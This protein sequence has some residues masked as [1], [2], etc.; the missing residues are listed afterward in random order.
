LYSLNF[1]TA[2]LLALSLIPFL[3][4]IG[5]AFSDS[6]G[7]PKGRTKKNLT[8]TL[9][10]DPPQ[11]ALTLDRRETKIPCGGLRGTYLGTLES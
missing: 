10:N 9:I 2:A 1:A 11:A 7:L 8:N 3:N 6:L 5:E 4:Q